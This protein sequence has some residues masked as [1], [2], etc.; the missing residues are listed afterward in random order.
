MSDDS[1]GDEFQIQE[2]LGDAAGD[3]LLNSD[4]F[5]SLS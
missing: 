2:T 5:Q 3:D 1:W 4:S